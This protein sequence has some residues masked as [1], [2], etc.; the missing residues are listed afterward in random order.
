MD[1]P[2]LSPVP[3]GTLADGDG[4]IGHPL[5]RDAEVVDVGDGQV[6]VPILDRGPGWV[7]FIN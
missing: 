2:S 7:W 5:H 6:A 4:G 1:G 3:F